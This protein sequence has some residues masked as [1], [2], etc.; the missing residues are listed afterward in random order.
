MKKLLSLVLLLSLLVS[1]A[2]AEGLR[3]AALKGPTAMGM[4]K[5]MSDNEA[6]ACYDF[7]ICAAADEITPQLAQGKLDIAALPANLASILYNRMDG[8]LQVLAVNTLGVLYIAERGDSVHSVADLRGKTIYSAGK[9]STPEYALNYILTANGLTPGEDVFIEFKSE[10]AEC[11]AALMNNAQA[12]AML[13]QPF[14]TTALAKAGDMRVA[15]DLTAEWDALQPE[16]DDKSAMITGVLVARRAVVEE[17]PAAVAQFMDDY[18][19]SVAF[20]QNNVSE[21]AQLVGDYGIVTAEVAEKA[22]PACKIVCITG[23]EMRASLSG[24]LQVLF[25]QSP[26]SVGGKLP[27]AEFYYNADK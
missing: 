5:M 6:T 16:G 24:Y 9:S 13:P 18:A 27:D 7:Q 15:L 3:V 8:A 1:C 25:D 11:L 14:M 2:A 10:H 17:N 23:E 4:V 26:D 22:L 19:A 12:V 20:A 21:A